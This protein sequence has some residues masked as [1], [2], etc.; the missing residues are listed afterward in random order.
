[1]GVEAKLRIERAI[2]T[3]AYDA[4]PSDPIRDRGPINAAFLDDFRRAGQYVRDL[5]YGRNAATGDILAVLN[6]CKGTCCT[7]HALLKVLASE[8]GLPIRLMLGIY[9]MNARNT[10]GVGHV[11]EE[12]HLH[13]RS[14]LLSSPPE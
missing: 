3:Y 7:K 2:L 12:Y 5:P 14:A 11:L 4:L 13:P 9:E 1:M 8:Q 6:E 10:P